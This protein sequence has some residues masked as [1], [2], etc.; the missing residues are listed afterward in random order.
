MNIA[1]KSIILDVGISALLTFIGGGSFYSFLF[2]LVILILPAILVFVSFDIAGNSSKN[3]PTKD[4]SK[5]KEI[6]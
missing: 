4:T 1:I 6:E 3:S 2:L 5:N